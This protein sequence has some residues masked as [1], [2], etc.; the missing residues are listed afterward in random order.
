[1]ADENQTATGDAQQNQ[2]PN[3]NV[4]VQYT[5]DLSFECPNAPEVF[6]LMAQNKAKPAIN[7]AHDVQVGR[8]GEGNA[9]EVMLSIKVEC[10]NSEDQKNMFLFEL[11]YAGVFVVEAPRKSYS[12]D[13]ICRGSPLI[14]PICTPNCIFYNYRG[15]FPTR[16][17]TTH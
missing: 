4:Q 11:A 6:L 2:A 9:Y 13:V 3:I 14:I 12:A 16:A 17:F 15:R 10:Q 1:M 5:K 7:V 8:L